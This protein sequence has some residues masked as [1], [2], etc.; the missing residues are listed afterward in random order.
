MRQDLFPSS[1]PLLHSSIFWTRLIASLIP[2]ICFWQTLGFWFEGD[3]FVWFQIADNVQKITDLPAYLFKPLAQGTV[4]FLSER[5]FFLIFYSLFGLEAL[6]LRIAILAALVLSCI[7]LVEVS[8][9]L[10]GSAITGILAVLFWC[11]QTGLLNAVAWISAANQIFCALFILGSLVAFIYRRNAICWTIYLLGFGVLETNVGLPAILGV[12]CLFFERP[13]LKETLLFWIPAFIFIVLRMLVFR[14]PNAGSEYQLLVAPA[15]LWFTLQSYLEWVSL[16]WILGWM[17]AYSVWRAFRKDFSTFFALSLF[18][19]LMAP[20]LPLRNH[21]S[22]YYLAAPGL[23][24]GLWLACCFENLRRPDIPFRETQWVAIPFILTIGFFHLQEIPEPR[25]HTLNWFRNTFKEIRL[26]MVDLQELR[27][28]DSKAVFVQGIAPESFLLSV[29]T[30]FSG[31]LSTRRVFYFADPEQPIPASRKNGL[32]DRLASASLIQALSEEKDVHFFE[33]RN[34]QWIRL[35]QLDQRIAHSHLPE[36]SSFVKPGEPG[37]RLHLTGS[38]YPPEENGLRAIH[39]KSGVFLY[40]QSLQSGTLNID[41]YCSGGYFRAGN[42]GMNILV[43]QKT[44]GTIYCSG[45][46]SSF[47]TSL[48]LPQDFHGQEKIHVEVIAG[49][50]LQEENKA[51]QT[52]LIREISVR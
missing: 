13:R 8:R 3:D 51:P 20:I 43:N 45:P 15:D 29:M 48:Q 10:T 38:W 52:V 50:S 24:F 41:G 27:N 22:Q 5:S 26:T 23:G 2:L 37:Y 39:Q 9:K 16:P 14:N 1:F 21:I 18:L 19:L 11:V 31:K 7:L 4:R 34:D 46:D 47:E 30:D 6:P 25:K 36:Y 17:L 40:A 49:Q 42:A 44:I 12:Y 32:K 33:I 35:N 28:H